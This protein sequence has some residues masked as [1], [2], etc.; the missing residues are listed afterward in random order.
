MCLYS[1]YDAF[2]NAH[3][4]SFLHF[5]EIQ[6]PCVFVNNF[7]HFRHILNTNQVSYR[8]YIQRM[9]K[10]VLFLSRNSRSK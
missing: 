10:A 9:N 4:A 5:V 8:L 7:F 3:E 6:N 1:C 2:K